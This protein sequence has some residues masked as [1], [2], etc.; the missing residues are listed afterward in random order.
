MRNTANRYAA[1]AMNTDKIRMDFPLLASGDEASRPVYLDSACQTLRPESVL[2]AMSD[3][4][5]EYPACAGRSSHRL[6]T[7][8]TIKCD[9]V[10]AKAAEFFGAADQAE[11][12]FMKNATEGLNT[13]IF[14]SGMR[15]GDLVVTTD[16][17]HNS[18]HVPLMKAQEEIGIKR[19]VIPSLKNGTFDLE[20]FEGIMS[21]DVRLVAMC[22]TSNVTGYTLPVREVVEIAHDNGAKVLLDAAQAAPSMRLDVESMGVD[23]LVASAHKMLGPSGVGLM[24]VSSESSGTLRPLTFGGHGVTGATL[25]SFKLLPPPERFEA[26]LQNYSGIIGTGAALDYLANVGMENIAEH[27]ISLNK[28][29]TRKLMGIP[30]LT[31]LEPLD[32]NLRKGILAFNIDGVHHH[33]VAIILDH[34]RNIMLRAGMLCCHSLFE[35]RRIEGCVRA[36]LYLYNTEAEVDI[37]ASALEGMATKL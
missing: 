14:G 16:Y 11:I 28:R 3:Y 5:S 10:R 18:V 31:I 4:Y 2:R 6:G 13:V 12:A 27:E 19:K 1:F 30:G 36:S 22:M 15:S 32:P 34:S 7:E 35:S 24:Y 21:K 9:D 29:M 33:D 8:V 20:A 23:Y 26:G 37:F 25:D 17:E